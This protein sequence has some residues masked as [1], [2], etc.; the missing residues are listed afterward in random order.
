[1]NVDI[2]VIIAFILYFVVVLGIGY[3]FYNRTHSMEDYVLGGR[4]LNPYVSAMSAQASDM[5]GWLLLGLPGAIFVAGLGEIWIGI[6][7]AI[8]SYLA[9]L[10]VAK[11]LRVYSEKCGNALT[12]PEFFSNRFRD[13]KGYLRLVSSIVILVFFTFYVTSGFVSGGNVFISI[14]GDI[15]Y[16]V[17]V[18]ITAGIIVVYT[19]MGGFKAVCWTDFVQA[20]LMLVAIIVV[21][22]AALG[23]IDGG[24]DHM[25][26]IV[27][28]E[29]ENFTNLGWD[30]GQPIT[31]IVLISCLA[32]GLG[33][34][35][36]PHIIVRYMAIKK[37]EEVKVAR[38]VGT[39]W[40]V[41]A[42]IG[43]ALIG[44]I[45]HGWA[46][47]N[48]VPVT[49][50]ERIFLEIIGSGMFVSVIAGV[51]Y[52]ALMAAVMSTAD[53]QLLVA[54]SAVTNDL[55]AKYSKK[56]VSDQK[57]MWISRCIVVAVA[58]LAAVFAMD[59]NSSIMSLVSFAWSGFGAAFGP[60]M[61]LALFWKRINA[62]GALAGMLT[63]FIVDVIWN[64][65]FNAGGII[66]GLLK[67]DWCVW[68][69]GLYELAPAFILAL[70]A[71]VIVSLLTE[72]PS[73]EM[74]KEFDEATEGSFW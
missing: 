64:T 27:N 28:S 71:A 52:A 18:W 56:E 2:G 60:I 4:E 74:Q 38:R 33:Y 63:G 17:A 14:F 69:S 66:P 9:W 8:G 62:K 68:N 16:K 72:E 35:G 29:V 20:L 22:M 1:M 13:E 21:P 31:A 47:A 24:W 65:F 53:S 26:N 32:W 44:M 37:P 50:P 23:H 73:E 70:I 39:A 67:V 48:G 25:V 46:V 34:F 42:L 49:N 19:F 15:D 43:A 45:G 59:E 3:Y 7:L 40:I 12:V 51:L 41:L 36:M 54:S 57:L 10:F 55:Y 58:L 11:R 6:G 5:S 61:I 30:G